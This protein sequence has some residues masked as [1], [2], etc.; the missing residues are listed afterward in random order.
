MGGG[1]GSPRSLWACYSLSCVL[2][3]LFIFSSPQD[4]RREIWVCFDRCVS[5]AMVSFR[6]YCGIKWK[7]NLLPEVVVSRV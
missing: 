3:V 4:L 6:K 7:V 5:P 1:G 2:D